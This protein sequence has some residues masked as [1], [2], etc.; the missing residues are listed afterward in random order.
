MLVKEFEAQRTTLRCRHC[1]AVGRLEARR[2]PNNNVQV[3]CPVCQQWDPLGGPAFLKQ[4]GPSTRRPLARPDE[5][6][7]AT[8]ARFGNRCAGCGAHAQH[9][10]QLGLRR[11]RQHAPPIAAVANEAETVLLPFCGD[12]QD[13]VTANQRR[14]ARLVRSVAELRTV[15]PLSERERDAWG[16]P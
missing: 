2:L 9:L 10:D 4:N 14:M 15:R 11:E 13:A 3:V 1:G 6:L 7:E 16:E 5:S 12:C 8:W